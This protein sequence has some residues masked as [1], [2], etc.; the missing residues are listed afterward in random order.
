M[1]LKFSHLK[2]NSC[3]HTDFV[4]TQLRKLLFVL[5]KEIL[6]KGIFAKLMVSHK[7]SY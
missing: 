4:H 3:D 6:S 5:N 2:V 7:A 1:S